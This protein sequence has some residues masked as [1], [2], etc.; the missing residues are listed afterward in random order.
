[1]TQE[2]ETPTAVPPWEN[3][4]ILDKTIQIFNDGE[5]FEFAIPSALHEIRIGAAIRKVRRVVDPDSVG[6]G[7]ESGWDTMAFLHTKAIAI[8]LTCLARTSAT[9]VYGPG[10]DGKP[11]IDWTNWPAESVERVL[12]ISLAFD[13]AVQRFRGR[14]N[15][16]KDPAKP[17]G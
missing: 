15:I 7:E 8:F 1:M 10:P 11:I 4:K 17:A 3:F 13:S 2:T 14:R 5:E 6:P 9:W 12:E 16:A